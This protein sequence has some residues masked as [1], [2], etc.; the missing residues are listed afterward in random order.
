MRVLPTIGAFIMTVA[1]TTFAHVTPSFAMGWVCPAAGIAQCQSLN[2]AGSCTQWSCVAS[3]WNPPPGAPK[4]GSTNPLATTNVSPIWHCATSNVPDGSLCHNASAC[5][6]SGTCSAG[7]CGAQAILQ[8][9]AS[10]TIGVQCS[11]LISTVNGKAT[12]G[13][14]FNSLDSQFCPMGVP[15]RVTHGGQIKG[16]PKVKATPAKN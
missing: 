15:T 8:C 7:G 14:M 9:P 5:I 1:A 16:G 4:V 3:P 13:D 11:C 10:K 6:L 2:V 12:C